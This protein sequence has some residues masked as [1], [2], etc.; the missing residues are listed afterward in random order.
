[1]AEAEIELV[2]LLE[3]Y[4]P[5]ST[6]GFQTRIS[7]K[8]E[9]A[10][11]A[12]DIAERLPPGRGQY[13]KHQ[14]FTHR[15]LRAYDRLV[16]LSET[17]TGKSCEAIGFIE[18]TR[19]EMEKARLDPATADEKASHF[20]RV[21]VLVGGSTQKSE[22]RRQVACKCSDG[23]YET[24]LVNNAKDES[25]QKRNLTSELTK[26]GYTV[27]TYGSFANALTREYPNAEDDARLAEDYSDTI[28][29][30]DEAHNLL[31]D[32]N[33]PKATREKEF[34]YQ[35]L[36]RVLH[37]ARRTK[38]IISTA[39]PMINFDNEIGSLMNLMLPPNGILPPGFDVK[40]VTDND[41]RV[42]F[43]GI[44]FNPRDRPAGEVEPYYVNQFPQGYD[45]SRAT[46]EDLEPIFRGKISYIRAADTGAIAQEQGI[47]QN[48]MYELNGVQYQSQLTLYASEI[49]GQTQLAGYNQ[50]LAALGGNKAF[51]SYERQAA[52]F[53]FPDGFAGGGVSEEEKA[54]R[55]A[56]KKLKA[57]AT[58]EEVEEVEVLEGGLIP[59]LL[60]GGDVEPETVDRTKMRAFA[61]YVDKTGDSYT[62]TPEFA[63]MITSVPDI[64]NFSSKY[65]EICQIV[66]HE[67]G[68]AFVYGEYVEGSGVVVLGL[69]LEA[70]GFERYNESRSMFAG[71]V[72]GGAKPFCSSDEQGA[73]TR[74]VRPNILPYGAMNPKSG[75]RQPF[76]YALLTQETTE[77][78]FHS[79]MEAMNSYENR[80]GDY[81]KVLISSR[82]GR[83]GINVN[84]VLQIHLIGPEWNQSNIY[85]ALSRG[86]RATSHENLLDEERRRLIAA[87]Q[88]PDTA[89]VMVKVY[90]HA[91]ISPQYG[92]ECV[93]YRMYQKS[94]E[95]DR[96][97]RRIL[98]FMKQTAVGCQ[99]H[100]N[101]NVRAGDIDGSQACDYDVCRY[102]CVDPPPEE[103][104]YSTYDILYAD[105]E[106]EEVISHI[107]NTFRQ[108]NA[109]TLDEIERLLPQFRP[110]YIVMALEQLVIHRRPL[111]DRFGYTSYLREDTGSFYLDREYP[112]ETT[113]E[114]AMAYYTD[115]IIGIEQ[116]DLADIVV[117]LEAGEHQEVRGELEQLP[118][119]TPEFDALIDELTIDG[120]VSLLEN[121]LLR[122]AQGENTPYIQAIMRKFENV[123]FQLHEPQTELRKVYEAKALN[124]PKRGRRPDPNTKRRT[125]KVDET[126]NQANIVWDEN[127]E[128]IYIHDLYVQV[129]DRTG[130]NTVAKVNKAEGRLRLLKPSQITTGWRDLDEVEAGVYN[131]LLQILIARRKQHLEDQGL[132]GFVLEDGKFRI[133]DRLT[134]DP[135]ANVDNRRV[136]RGRVCETWDRPL[137]VDL[138]WDLRIEEPG[139]IAP[140]SRGEMI[141]FL[142][143]AKGFN[144]A[145]E[146]Q[147]WDMNQLAYYYK[148]YTA[149]RISRARMCEAIKYN[150]EVNNRILK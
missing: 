69:C 116:R 76:R 138:V 129:T 38:I 85:Q 89:R 127:T 59:G 54:R 22:F 45:F 107:L 75:R 12:S 37:L 33:K 21:V 36:W 42:L 112:T 41:I 58:T 31:I 17:G 7:A 23:R 19:K 68:N 100:Y 51:S 26:V 24:P 81:I 94:E 97:I 132:Y 130:Y 55:R 113:A 111:T 11:L 56:L 84:N 16:I 30:I 74:R 77:A 2:D 104:D 126:A 73:A 133:R 60:G 131:I 115:G 86:L 140:A 63:R 118:P 62:A 61:R 123:I 106:V 102:Q 57:G 145:A 134:E 101:R 79:L 27:S 40:L 13:Y 34:T 147:T 28:F 71:V 48:Q 15:F 65:A 32:P 142:L 148:W 72:G 139:G 20:K 52:N 93:D 99:V 44:P 136:K 103:I 6:P 150:M 121:A 3:S 88:N 39:T 124:K 144:H 1:M 122:R 49:L 80:H 90:K 25:V 135:R 110:K 149:T 108:R 35:T 66:M 125:K 83:D 114:Y 141:Q 29:W 98:R 143:G 53:I 109:L 117:E 87:G 92:T 10:E 96:S 119:D 128:E 47:L 95:K 78:K 14:K 137:L 67:P 50:V 43:P 4:P 120:R 82:V 46:L 91:A 64:A 70:L 9:F 8:K 18:Y 146:V 105:E 5:T